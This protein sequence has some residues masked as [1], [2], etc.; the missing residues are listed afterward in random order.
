MRALRRGVAAGILVVLSL[1]VPALAG[2]RPRSDNSSLALDASLRQE[3]REAGFTG[4]IESTLTARLGR[5]LNPGLANV[6]RLIWFDP[7]TGLNDDNACAGCHSPANGFGD[8]QSIAIGI[9]SNRVV[10][11]NRTGPRNQRRS[12]MV[13]N[14]AFYPR[15]M[16]NGRFSS[17]SGDPFDRRMGFLF[18]SPEGTSL[19]YLPHLLDAQAFIPPT[20]R[21]EAAGFSF[22]GDNDAIR[23]E[24]IRRLNAT[25]EY[26]K[27]FERVFPEVREGAPI[28]YE[29]VAHAIAE[30]EFALT[31]ANAP[32]DRYARGE[33]T[34]LTEQ[35]KRGALLFFGEAGCVSCHAVAA[36]S[37]E[38]FSDFRE[39]VLAVPQIAP[40]HTNVVFDGPGANED[41]G[42]EQVTGD[43]AD[44]YA[45][46][47]SPLR[48]VALQPA[49]MHNGAFTSLESAV[50]HHLDVVRS[51][52]TYDPAAAGLD[53]DLSEAVAPVEPMLSRI[54]PLLAKPR[55]FS[56]SQVDALVAFLRD[57]LLDPRARPKSLRRLVPGSL[58]SGREPLTFEFPE[59]RADR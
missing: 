2:A 51:A 19:S 32:I 53:P 42:L 40:R 34:A 18:P 52:L 11:P 43:S 30:F 10:G 59:R 7:I 55:D 33:L 54:D 8:T 12:P 9:D 46:R 23:A 27:L 58:P 35:G 3:L 38:M 16:W 24:V 17:V 45:F 39:H 56:R 31:F 20:E 29:M 26:G 47:T 14:T 37:N 5:P 28:T 57:G 15:L 49:F 6:G 22:R 21:V 13:V 4:Q 41:F 50:R 25:P 48:N 44:R 1:L 36:G